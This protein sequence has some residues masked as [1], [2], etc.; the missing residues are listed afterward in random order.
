VEEVV[1]M[2]VH[3]H[4]LLMLIKMEDQEVEQEILADVIQEEQ[5]ILLQ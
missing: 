3:Q 4:L 2:V 1:F 5:E